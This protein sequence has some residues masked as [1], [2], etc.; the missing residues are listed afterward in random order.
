MIM[1]FALMTDH[2][3]ILLLSVYDMSYSLTFNMEVAAP[4]T[5]PVPHTTY[6]G[7]GKKKL[8]TGIARQ[9]DVPSPTK[10]TS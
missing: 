7:E 2:V 6:I 9:T 4:N 8:M 3:V 1:P 10:C 5:K